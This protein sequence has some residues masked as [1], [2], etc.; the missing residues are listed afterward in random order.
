MQGEVNSEPQRR[1]MGLPDWL[2]KASKMIAWLYTYIDTPWG[3]DGQ[4]W[5]TMV[6]Q[7][8]PAQGRKHHGH[9]TARPLARLS[10]IAGTTE[11]QSSTE[12]RKNMFFITPFASTLP[13]EFLFLVQLRIQGHQLR[14]EPS[15]ISAKSA[16]WHPRLPTIE[17]KGPYP[18]KWHTLKPFFNS[19]LASSKALLYVFSGAVL[20]P[21]WWTTPA[22]G[23]D[24][25]QVGRGR[26]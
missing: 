11:Q 16:P 20:H 26:I 22:W 10:W 15:M 4:Q 23:W 7:R 17:P 3:S 13:G 24:P 1:A 18:Q 21:R 2:L 6:S 8:L 5:S 25:S 14:I 12:E 9:S 19:R